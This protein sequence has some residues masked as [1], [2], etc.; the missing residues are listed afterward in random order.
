MKHRTTVTVLVIS[1][2]DTF[3]PYLVSALTYLGYEATA[4]STGSEALQQLHQDPRDLVLVEEDLPD[5]LGHAI[6][7][8]I[9]K[10]HDMP[11]IMLSAHPAEIREVAALEGGCDDY[12][13]KAC[14]LGTLAARMRRS[15]E[16]RMVRAGRSTLP[17]ALC[18]DRDRQMIAIGDR[19]VA[20]TTREMKL[21]EV[22]LGAPHRVF[23][24][25][26]LLD[27]VWGLES[28]DLEVRTVD[29]T[30]ARLR[31][32]LQ[33]HF[34]V[35]PIETVPGAGYRYRPENAP[36]EFLPSEVRP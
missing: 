14:S 30:I 22:L 19:S 12:L 31:K 28:L 2:D 1:G 34:A 10:E 17:Q 27:R 32:K 6:G 7:H 11:V 33:Q 4:A 13:A 29:A 5:G 20:L 15:L 25:E 21:C 16:R 35:N 9:V 8:Q 26:T 36:L 23:S 18:I 24:R 3:R